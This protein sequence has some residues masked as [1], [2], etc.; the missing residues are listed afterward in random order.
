MELA[1]VI[2]FSNSFK[3][4]IED[5]DFEDS[6]ETAQC[7]DVPGDIPNCQKKT[8]FLFGLILRDPQKMSMFFFVWIQWSVVFIIYIY[9]SP[10]RDHPFGTNLI[11]FNYIN[12]YI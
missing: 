2:A 5:R 8:L 7:E 11:F 6:L 12:I 4:E 1:Q 3:K 9:I 10:V